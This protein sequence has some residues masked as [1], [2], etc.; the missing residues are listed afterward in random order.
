V[1]L[2]P[3]LTLAKRQADAFVEA[4]ASAVLALRRRGSASGSARDVELRGA[5]ARRSGLR[6]RQE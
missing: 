4:L 5:A 3:P 2:R 1:R 6:S